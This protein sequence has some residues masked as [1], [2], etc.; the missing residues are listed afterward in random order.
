VAE[1]K[2]A[3]T[4]ATVERDEAST[5]VLRTFVASI[6][7]WIKIALAASVIA[8][9]LAIVAVLRSRRRLA[10]ALARAY[11]DALTGLP[12]RAAAD[13]ELRSLSSRAA[14]SGESLGVLMVDIDHFKSINDTYGHGKGDEVLKGVAAI[15]RSA[16][17]AGDFV[18]RVGGEE[19]LV[20]LPDTDLA[21][22]RHVAEGLRLAIR[23]AGVGDLEWAVTASVGVAAGR[24]AEQR[25]RDLTTT[26]DA[27]LYR[28]KANGRDRVEIAAASAHQDALAG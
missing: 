2:P 8:L 26:A 25:L 17:R 5:M 6:P 16:V 7:A 22:A 19:L 9:L 28:A 3:A 18:G 4:S 20:L 13:E 15:A 10:D 27:A 21:G 23:D 24:G 1:K 11:H 14:R 12:N